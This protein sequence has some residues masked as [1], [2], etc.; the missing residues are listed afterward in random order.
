MNAFGYVNLSA[1]ADGHVAQ[2]AFDG[3]IDALLQRARIRVESQQRRLVLVGFV[4]ALAVWNPAGGCPQDPA[5]RVHPERENRP[6]GLGEFLSVASDD[7]GL[8]HAADEETTSLR[9]V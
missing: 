5:I 6:R 8:S 1:A 4:A 2:Q 9:I 3:R 7:L